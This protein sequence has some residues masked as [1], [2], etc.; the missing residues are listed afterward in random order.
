[1]DIEVYQYASSGN[2]DPI[3]VALP[4]QGYIEFISGSFEAGF[5]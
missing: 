2:P 4:N 5:F 1:M 3:A